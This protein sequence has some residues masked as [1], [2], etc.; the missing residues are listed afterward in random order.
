VEKLA[1]S[2]SPVSNQKVIIGITN[3]ADTPAE[4][5]TMA[6]EEETMAKEEA[7]MAIGPTEEIMATGI[8]KEGTMALGLMVEDRT[9]EEAMEEI[10]EVEVVNRTRE[11]ET[12]PGLRAT[13]PKITLTCTR[14]G[15]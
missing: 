14:E 4:E 6:K 15:T 9:K 3:G 7:T 10:M 12:R 1:T 5:E 11:A 2:P 8:T 13:T